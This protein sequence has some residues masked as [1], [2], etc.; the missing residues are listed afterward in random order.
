MQE[1]IVIEK[2]NVMTVFTSAEG[3]DPYV[4]MV[5]DEVDKH[6]CDLSTVKGRSEIASL[7]NKVAKTKVYMDGLGKDLVSEWKSKSKVV[8]ASR[9]FMRDQLDLLKVE[10]RKPLTDW[11]DSEKLRLEEEKAKL[12]AELLAKQIESDHEIG[13]LMNNEFDRVAAEKIEEEKRLQEERD[14]AEARL[15]ELKAE[16][17]K[18][19]REER[20]K[21]IA[22]EAAA[23]AEQ[24]KN[25]AE[26][27]AKQA[28]QDKIHAQERAKI[29]EEQ[30]KERAEMAAKEAV[31][32]EELHRKRIE[33]E[34]RI[35]QQKLEANKVHVGKIRKAAKESLM[36][37]CKLTEAQAKSVV[38]AINKK[39]I[40]NVS[41]NY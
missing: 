38:L 28:E 8:D 19:A 21:H 34:K 22:Q 29:I 26:A 9:K 3:L 39:A 15:T 4:Q 37:E 5:R 20:E 41:I 33:E 12:E 30:S 40:A 6:E 25:E 35:K 1:L 17:E 7:A 36:L 24:E 31:E 14:A 27:L 10:V 18:V 2:I 32:R 16:Q 23:K 13:I 11:E